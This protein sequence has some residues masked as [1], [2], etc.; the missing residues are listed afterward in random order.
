MHLPDGIASTPV[1]AI[2][3]GIAVAG[4]A[5]GLRR[6]TPETLPPAAMAASVFF[7]ASLVHIPA[8][9]TSVHLLLSGLVGLVLGWIAFPAI[10]TGLTLQ[11]VFFGFGG[12]TVLG[13]NTVILAA[14]AVLTGVVARSF[15]VSGPAASNAV[16][17][18][19]A[20]AAAVTLSALML[21]GTLALSGSEFRLAAQFVLLAHG[22]IIVVETAIT[23]S[24]VA[25]ICRVKPEILISPKL[26][27]RSTQD[28]SVAVEPGP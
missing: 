28:R 7:V 6:L 10:L 22:P 20:G 19:L 24:A 27:A 11:A 1:L 13:V 18:G 3:T 26:T 5:M 12:L 16:W 21:G 8:G 25:L 17:G 15:L 2:G 4:V 9:V 23:A 14:P